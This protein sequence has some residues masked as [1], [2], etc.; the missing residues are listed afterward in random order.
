VLA[1]ANLS[2]RFIKNLDF[3]SIGALP[4]ATRCTLIFC[5]FGFVV[6]LSAVVV[7]LEA[8]FGGV[9]CDVVV[10]LLCWSSFIGE[11][12]AC[13]LDTVVLLSDLIAFDCCWSSVV[14]DVVI[15]RLFSV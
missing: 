1:T 9:S 11:S 3:L 14:G 4:T 15:I 2:F 7:C 10:L 6:L 5:G 8:S 12:F 13:D